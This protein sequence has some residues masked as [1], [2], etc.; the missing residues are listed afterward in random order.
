MMTIKELITI[1]QKADSDAEVRIV[2]QYDEETGERYHNEINDVQFGT[3]E[4]DNVVV[5][6]SDYM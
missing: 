5:L 1:L 6:E 3:D 4:E 2:T